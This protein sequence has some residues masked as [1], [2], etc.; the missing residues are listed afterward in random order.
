LPGA[1][2]TAASILG[3]LRTNDLYDR[4]DNYWEAVAPRYRAMSVA[5]MDSA[6]RAVIDPSRFVWVIVGDA[7]VVRPQLE[8]LG[9]PIEVVTP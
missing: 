9:L 3:A 4:P 8:G 5:D 6:A 1:Y 7:S 2:E